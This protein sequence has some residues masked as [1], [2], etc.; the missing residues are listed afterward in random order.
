MEIFEL[1]VAGGNGNDN[2]LG[3]ALNKAFPD[4]YVCFGYLGNYSA[5]NGDGFEFNDTNGNRL[6]H[7]LCV[8]K[9]TKITLNFENHLTSGSTRYGCLSMGIN[10]AVSGKKVDYV[11]LISLNTGSRNYTLSDMLLVKGSNYLFLCGKT[12]YPPF[13]SVIGYVENG[14]VK[15]FYGFGGSLYG[16]FTDTE[17]GAINL[18][19]DATR[20]ITTTAAVDSTISLDFSCKATVEYNAKTDIALTSKHFY[21]TTSPLPRGVAVTISSNGK[22]Y[23]AI[24]VTDRIIFV[25]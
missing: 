10:E 6:K 2:L 1:G 20:V 14:S 11:P 23:T 3:M 25:E 22:L 17:I 13:Y 5:P 18:S 7:S 4:E 19:P 21:E 8:N 12:S 24:S 9:K 16:N 15:S